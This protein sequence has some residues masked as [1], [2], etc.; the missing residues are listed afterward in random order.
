[1]RWGLKSAGFMI[2]PRAGLRPMISY[3]IIVWWIKVDQTKVRSEV[4]KVQ[5]LAFLIIKGPCAP[6]PVC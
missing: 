6:V 4:Q 2:I 5:C 1:M 3:D